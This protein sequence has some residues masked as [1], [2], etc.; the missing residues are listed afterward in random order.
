[1]LKKILIAVWVL[2]M[3]GILMVAALFFSISHGWIGYMPDMNELQN[4]TYKFASQVL[5]ADGQVL[6]N[7]SYSK[8]NRV[9]VDYKDISPN[10]IKALIATEDVRF[11]EH[12]G[13]DA[14]ALLRVVVKTGLLFQK[15]S[16]GGSTI[17][18]QLA[19]LLYSEV[20]GNKLERLYQ[21]PIEWV[22]AVELERH[23]TKEEI[24][25][26][27][28]NKY[29]FG[30]NAVGIKSAA[31]VYF[32]KLPSELN[33]QEAAMLVGMCKNSSLYNPRRRPEMTRQRRNVVFAQMERAGC[34]T[35]EEFEVLKE[36]EMKLNF[37]Y[38]M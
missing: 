7:W 17:T 12:S 8:E 9:F 34:I 20:S 2:F 23:Y 10:L 1:M 26:M 32:G 3:A 35:K 11:T 36:T 38:L 19:K 13:I 22:I 16:G 25:T 24:I 4:P 21:K 30:Y 6:G 37:H 14:R 27:Y 33:M 29:D 15:N 18:Q 31:N 5:S 28:L